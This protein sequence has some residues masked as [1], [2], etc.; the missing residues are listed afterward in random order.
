MNYTSV[1]HHPVSA[2]CDQRPACAMDHGGYTAEW[3]IALVRADLGTL[4]GSIV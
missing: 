3:V 1:I 2:R 4:N